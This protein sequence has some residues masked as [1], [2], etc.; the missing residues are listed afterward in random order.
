M[1]SDNRVRPHTHTST[2]KPEKRGHAKQEAVGTTEAT[3]D[4]LR[5]E[6]VPEAADKGQAEER[7]KLR[8]EAG[9]L[10]SL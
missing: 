7:D 6:A 10:L 4:K 2:P 9:R 3:R 5:R 8:R 1:T